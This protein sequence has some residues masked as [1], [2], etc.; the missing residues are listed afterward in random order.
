M[1]VSFRHVFI[2]RSGLELH[3]QLQGALALLF[4]SEDGHD[5]AALC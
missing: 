1:C 4:S 3:P 2:R 5:D